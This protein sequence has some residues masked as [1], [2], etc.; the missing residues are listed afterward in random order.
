MQRMTVIFLLALV[1]A[2]S[3]ALAANIN[4]VV[5]YTDSSFLSDSLPFTAGYEFTTTVPFTINALGYWYDGNGYSHDVGLWNSNGQLLISTTVQPNDPVS[6]H[7]Q[8]DSVR[9]TLAP[10]TYVIGGQTY[11][12]GNTYNFPVNATGI[13]SLP[14]YSWVEDRQ[15]AGLG[16]N[17]PTATYGTYG[18]NGIFLVDFSVEAVPEPGTLFLMGSG[19]AGVFGLCRRKFGL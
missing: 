15:F 2:V 18:D 9:Y 16:L 11:E 7:F 3:P 8:Y 1:G 19:V 12:S 5:E 13:T 17:F 4:P 10:G 6:G 14:G